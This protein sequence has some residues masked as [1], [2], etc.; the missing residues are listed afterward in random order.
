MFLSSLEL[1]EIP[2]WSRAE[3]DRDDLND[4]KNLILR[5]DCAIRLGWLA[6]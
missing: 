6:K 4:S 5:V 1:R 2:R 3:F